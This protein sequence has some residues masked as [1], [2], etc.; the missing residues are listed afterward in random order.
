MLLYL[1]DDS[2]SDI[3]YAVNCHACNMFDPC[4]S[5]EKALKQIGRY[6]KATRDKGLVL[7][8]SDQLKVNAY[9]DADFTRLYGHKKISKNLY[10]FS[11]NCF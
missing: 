6:L 9:P 2:R 7:N 5:H 4:L 11:A 3:A 1:S 10:W 8:L